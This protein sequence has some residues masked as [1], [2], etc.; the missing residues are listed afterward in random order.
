MEVPLH[1]VFRNMDRSEAVEA[2][3]H[4]KVARLERFFERVVSCSVT[5]EASHRRHHKGNLYSCKIDIKVPNK[6]IVINRTGPNDHAHE[7]V[8]VA[9]RDAFRAAQRKLEDYARTLRGEIK[10]HEEPPLGRIARLF[11]EQ[12]Y[13]FVNMLDGREVYFHA[14]SVVGGNFEDLAVDAHVRVAVA[15]GEGRDGPQASMVRPT[16]RAQTAAD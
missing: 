16:G 14:N 9:V 7:D 13:G 15:E 1:I 4:E 2:R 6:E 5:V 3:I 8:Y 10:A 12:G 11:P